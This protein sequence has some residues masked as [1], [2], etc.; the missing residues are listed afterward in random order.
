MSEIS[1]EQ[2]AQSND[3]PFLPESGAI[4]GTANDNEMSARERKRLVD[5]FD[6]LIE[7]HALLRKQYKESE[8]LPDE[9]E[10]RRLLQLYPVG[11]TNHPA[12]NTSF[13]TQ[14]EDQQ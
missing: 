8:E 12:R 2:L 3:T 13:K 1:S 4:D 11:E 14:S 7:A 6:W 9:P 5:L 10:I